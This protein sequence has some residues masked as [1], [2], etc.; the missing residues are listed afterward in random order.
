MDPEQRA[1]FMV[2]LG[3][4]LASL[5]DAGQRHLRALIR[6]APTPLDIAQLLKGENSTEHFAGLVRRYARASISGMVPKFLAPEA[7]DGAQREPI[8]KP[9]LRLPGDAAARQCIAALLPTGF[10]ARFAAVPGFD[11]QA[12]AEA[13]ILA[14]VPGLPAAISDRAGA[15]LLQGDWESALAV[16][17]QGAQDAVRNAAQ[18]G[19]QEA[20]IEV[21][22]QLGWQGNG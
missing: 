17:L 14:A 1:P 13:A 6:E 11:A 21:G 9:T 12:R 8:G 7:T 15:L 3:R 20:A 16:C 10:V 19:L 18:Q 2:R 4:E 5:G 22:V